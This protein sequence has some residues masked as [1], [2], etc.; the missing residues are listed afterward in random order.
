[1]EIGLDTA[2]RQIPL[3][4]DGAD[5]R[6][7]SAGDNSSASSADRIPDAGVGG[8]SASTWSDPPLD[9]PDE[10]EIF[11]HITSEPTHIDDLA[12]LA[13]RPITQVSSL[14]TMLELKGLVVQVGMMH[15]QRSS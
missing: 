14:L 15:Y 11:R 9:D 5:A 6:E 8:P 12:R 10:L 3:S 7:A 4:L 13:D 1:M 2:E